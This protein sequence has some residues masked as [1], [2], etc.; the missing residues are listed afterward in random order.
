MREPERGK[1]FYMQVCRCRRCGGILYSRK[2]VADGYGCKCKIKAAAEAEAWARMRELERRG[3]LL[4]GQRS[5][6]RE[7]AREYV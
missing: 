7:E 5:L 2:A 4:A 1:P 6:F 3:Q